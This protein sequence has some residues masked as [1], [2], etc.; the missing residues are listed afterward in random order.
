M[1]DV[2][3]ATFGRYVFA[4]ADDYIAKVLREQ[5]SWELHL[6][7]AFLDVLPHRNIRGADIGAN[8]GLFSIQMAL[9]AAQR[10]KTIE[11]DAFEVQRSVFSNLQQNIELNGLEDEHEIQSEQRMPTEF[12]SSTE[13]KC[14]LIRSTILLTRT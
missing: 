6:C 1:H 14:D 3:E 13:K 11:I 7:M 10:G 9:L 5:G 12:G 8:V 4:N 2:F